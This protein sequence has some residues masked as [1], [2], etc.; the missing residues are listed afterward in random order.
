M[1]S[2]SSNSE[3]LLPRT[4]SSSGFSS[5]SSDSSEDKV[6]SSPPVAEIWME[7]GVTTKEEPSFASRDR[8]AKGSLME[9]TR[10]ITREV[11]I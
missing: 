5:M 7:E 8:A 1:N 9:I 3:I 6:A 11:L 4:S 2:S 10:G